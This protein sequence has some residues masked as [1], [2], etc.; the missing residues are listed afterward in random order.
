MEVVTVRGRAPLDNLRARLPLIFFICCLVNLLNWSLIAF[1]PYWAPDF[2]VFWAASRAALVNPTLVY[3]STALTVAQMWIIEPRT[4]F[5]PWAYP[6]TALLPLLPFSKLTF[7]VAY[8][9]FA[10]TTAGLYAIAAKRFLGI[11]WRFGLAFLFVSDAF[12]FAAINGQMTFLIGALI[13]GGI[14]ALDDRP[15]LAGCLFGVAAAIKPQLLILT[16]L[17]LIASQQYRAL[18]SAA[19]T[20]IAMVVFT[21]PLGVSLWF[22]WLAALPKFLLIV[23]K[24]DILG[25]NVTPVGI[26]WNIGVTGIELKLIGVIFACFATLIVWNVFRNDTDWTKRLVALVGGG[27]W[28]SPYAM[29]YELAILAPAAI[30]LLLKGAR[31][32]ASV[33]LMAISGLFLSSYANWTPPI[34]LAFIAMALKDHFH[35]PDSL[36]RTGRRI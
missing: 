8:V 6:P 13:L 35:V 33:P 18:Y 1:G 3:D 27:L 17:A 10:A 11:D 5:R 29:N 36:L 22:D 16:P 24:L 2:T 12:L 31:L 15:I 7:G 19:F 21:L 9:A 32:E 30:A 14:I 23:E 28:C 20:A 26:F 4:G 34:A 25:R